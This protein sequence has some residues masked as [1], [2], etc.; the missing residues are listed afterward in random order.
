MLLT[1]KEHVSNLTFKLDEELGQTNYEI[2][3]EKFRNEV[4][5]SWQ[6]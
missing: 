2:I 5:L 3:R 1:F 4:T 6:W